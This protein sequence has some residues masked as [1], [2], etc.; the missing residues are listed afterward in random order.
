MQGAKMSKSFG[1]II[2]LVDGIGKFGADPLRLGILATAELL[3]DADF[4][5]TLARSMKDR[6]EQLYRRGEAIAKLKTT[7]IPEKSLTSVDKWMLSRLQSRIEAATE[8]MDKLAVRKAIHSALYELDKDLEWYKRRIRAEGEQA[9][10]KRVV[11]SIFSEVLDA[12]V[13]MLAPVTP[14]IC[15]ELWEKMG[16]KG[17]VSLAA[18][19]TPDED[20]VDVEAEENEALIES[21]LEDTLNIIKATGTK[22]NKVH[23]YVAA[24]WKWKAYLTV[25]K[26][27]V[28]GKVVQGD[29]MK[30]LMADEKRRKVAK[31]LAKFVEQ[32]ICEVNQIS[33]ESKQRQLQVGEID[34]NKTLIEAQDFIKR[35]LKAEVHVYHEEDSGRYDPRNRSS[36]AKPNRPAIYIE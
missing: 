34:E 14:H 10:R 33:T 24:P 23:Y 3:Q 6:L 12:Q 29:V 11:D 4:S 9:Q 21:V 32:V 27:S 5:P 1:N 8:A 35:E 7:G 22:P 19:P 18:W 2:P 36:L 17:F 28:S 20:R 15:E 31:Q 16:H 26:K 30:E 25:L 13:R